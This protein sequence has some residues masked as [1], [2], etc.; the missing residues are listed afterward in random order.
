MF[1]LLEKSAQKT[2][3]AER[4]KQSRLSP[5]I[6]EVNQAYESAVREL[7]DVLFK[8][9]GF[10]EIPTDIAERMKERLIHAELKYREDHQ[11]LSEANIVEVINKLVTTF[12]APDYAKT[13]SLQVRFMR[14]SLRKYLPHLVAV[15]TQEDRMGLRQPVGTGMNPE[16]APVEA[17]FLTMLMIQQKMLNDDWQQ[18]PDE[19]VANQKKRYLSRSETAAQNDTEP[20]FGVSPETEDSQFGTS[21]Q[22]EERQRRNDEKRNEMRWLVFRTAARLNSARLNHLVESSLDTLGIAKIEEVQQ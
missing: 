2:H 12:G 14:A 20:Q 19:W 10:A 13:S 5:N 21:T 3:A 9:F 1:E 18:T 17:A 4:V 22:D 16:V 15:E 11:G 8:E 6:E 7:V